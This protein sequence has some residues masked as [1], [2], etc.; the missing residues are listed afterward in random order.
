MK[1]PPNYFLLENVKDFELSES[2][3][4]LTEVQFF[5]SSC[6]SFRSTNSRV[7]LD[8]VR[9]QCTTLYILWSAS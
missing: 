8:S 6:I 5:L 3:K 4:L 1:H 9:L 7:D 2:F